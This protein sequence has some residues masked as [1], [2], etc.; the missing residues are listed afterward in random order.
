M[1]NVRELGVQIG[2][3]LQHPIVDYATRLPT[4]EN[5]VA[6]IVGPKLFP[7]SAE[8]YLA[9][10]PPQ[11]LISVY[12]PNSDKIRYSAKF[13][14]GQWQTIPADPSSGEIEVGVVHTGYT[15]FQIA[16]APNQ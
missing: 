15:L 12:N 13:V 6:Q 11:H 7:D 14:D 4:G 8:V 2:D 3:W 16:Q 1:P 10:P 9:P 5:H